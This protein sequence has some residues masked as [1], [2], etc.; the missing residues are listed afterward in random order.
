MGIRYVDHERELVDKFVGLSSSEPT[1]SIDHA[2]SNTSSKPDITVN[3]PNNVTLG[4][5]IRTAHIANLGVWSKVGQLAG[6][7]FRVLIFH[8]DLRVEP[9][10]VFKELL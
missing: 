3:D 8:Q 9:R 4:L 7:Q 1:Q 6:L 10:E 5:S 2:A